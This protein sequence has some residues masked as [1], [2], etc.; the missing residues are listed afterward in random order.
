MSRLVGL[1]GLDVVGV[2][3]AVG[4]FSVLL[5]CFGSLHVVAVRFSYLY[6]S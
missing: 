6:E 4:L 3:G 5:Q 2:G 1:V